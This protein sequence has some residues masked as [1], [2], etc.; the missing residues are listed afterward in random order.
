M[1]KQAIQWAKKLQKEQKTIPLT[2]ITLYRNI[3]GQVTA[4]N[5]KIHIS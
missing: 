4:V 1:G 5:K 3:K 2:T